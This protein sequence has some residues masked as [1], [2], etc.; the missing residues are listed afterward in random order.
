MSWQGNRDK[1]LK[2]GPRV[3]PLVLEAEVAA[4]LQPEGASGTISRGHRASNV[5]EQ[6]PRPPYPM[7]CVPSAP[8]P[9]PQ[10]PSP[11]GGKRP[12]LPLQGL[13]LSSLRPGHPGRLP[14]AQPSPRLGQLPPWAAPHMP[15]RGLA[16]WFPSFAE[17]PKWPPMA[18]GPGTAPGREHRGPGCGARVSEAGAVVPEPRASL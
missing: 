16:A 13:W 9:A 7:V 18:P 3:Q 8:A 5:A 1:A 10:L 14:E 15:A 2:K 6:A 11:S 12:P 4:G 17:T